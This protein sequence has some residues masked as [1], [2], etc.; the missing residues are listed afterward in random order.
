MTVRE[1]M[2]APELAQFPD[3]MRQ[4]IAI[5]REASELQAAG[6]LD[7]ARFEELLD[8]ICRITPPGKTSILVDMLLRKAPP[9]FDLDD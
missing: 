1:H 2:E 7:G 4:S 3:W 9:E 5:N 6:R 8:E